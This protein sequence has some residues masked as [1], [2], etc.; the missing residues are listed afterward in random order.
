MAAVLL[1][2]AGSSSAQQ[3]P[4]L[5]T[6]PATVAAS[7]PDLVVRRASLTQERATLHG[8]IDSLNAH[9]GSVE[10][11]SA[12]ESSCKRDQGELQSAL[13]SHIQQSKDFNA[14]AQAVK[15][16]STSPAPAAVTVVNLALN[17]HLAEIDRIE[18]REIE[19]RMARLHKA[20]EILQERDED[21]VKDGKELHAE[22][23]NQDH[24]VDWQA[25]LFATAGLGEVLKLASSNYV[26]AAEAIQR[27]SIWGEL[28]I[29]KANLQKM[30]VSAHGQDAEALTKTIDALDRVERAHKLKDTVETGK[31]LQEAMEL[32]N[33]E[34]QRLS[35]LDRRTADLLYESSAFMGRTAIIFGKGVV[36]KCSA[37]AS[38]AEPFAEASAVYLMMGEEEQQMKQLSNRLADRQTMRRQ[39]NEQLGELENR[40]QTLQWAIQRADPSISKRN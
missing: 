38:F 7:N 26:E 17:P 28:P 10:E 6:L 36:E 35:S 23:V 3:I 5:T 29:E 8:K 16:A 13:N 1:G 4:A 18:L 11:G 37:V 31:K 32:E 25:F 9:C 14:A 34:M 27:D 21:A 33:E 2:L 12:A 40:Q 30:L 15:A 24:E 39:I 19:G 20:L 22:M